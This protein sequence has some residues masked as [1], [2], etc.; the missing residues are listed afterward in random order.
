L[1]EAHRHLG[2][3]FVEAYLAQTQAKG[4]HPH[5]R[6]RRLFLSLIV[7][8]LLNGHPEAAIARWCPVLGASEK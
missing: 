1:I 3:G 7:P 8:L 4:I 5:A 6:Y 2:L